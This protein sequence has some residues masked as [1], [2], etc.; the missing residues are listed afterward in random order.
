MA[1]TKQYKQRRAQLLKEFIANP[2]TF[3]IEIF[4]KQWNVTIQQVY[5]DLKK[6]QETTD[7]TD[8][9]RIKIKMY[10][11]YATTEKEIEKR[12]NASQTPREYIALTHL[13][14]KHRESF[15]EF[16]EKFGIKQKIP[17]ESISQITVKWKDALD[18]GNNT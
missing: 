4:G 18:D 11:S 14:T 13:Q 15:I 6:I 9:D 2:F 7:I 5:N 8:I 3:N 17:E 1:S 12:K 10:H 16:M